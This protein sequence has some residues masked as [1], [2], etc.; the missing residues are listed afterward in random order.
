MY[1]RAGKVEKE[2]VAAEVRRIG[3]AVAKSKHCLVDFQTRARREHVRVLL[4]FMIR[5]ETAFGFTTVATYHHGT[6]LR[7]QENKT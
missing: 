3:G 5:C 4:F 7:Q 1:A 2:S 6:Q